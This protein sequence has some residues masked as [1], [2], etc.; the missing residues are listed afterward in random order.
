MR[1]N[2][3]YL[4]LVICFLVLLSSCA[5]KKAPPPKPQWLYQKDAITLRF[6][7][8][9][10][11]NM[12]EGSPHTLMVCVYQLSNDNMMS[13]LASNEDGIYQLLDCEHY[14]SSVRNA[15]RLIIHPE[16]DLT[17][18]MDRLAGT[19]KIAFVAGYAKLDKMRMVRV[20]D[21]PVLVSKDNKSAVATEMKAIVNLGS[22]QIAAIQK[23]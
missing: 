12:S 5:S 8:D 22:E 6:K 20:V 3:F 9:S 21:I 1:R 14:D 18:I 4:L 16:Q 15:K 23:Y 13:Q 10:V 17:F 19:Q 11:L 2:I 7:A